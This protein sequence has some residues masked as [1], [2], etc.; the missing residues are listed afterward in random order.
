MTITTT[1]YNVAEAEMNIVTKAKNY[2]D[3]NEIQRQQYI[4]NVNAYIDCLEENSYKKS[5]LTKMRNILKRNV[6][7]YKTD[8]YVHDVPQ[9]ILSFVPKNKNNFAFVWFTRTN[10]THLVDLLQ[11]EKNSDGTKYLFQENVEL[12]VKVADNAHIIYG[13]KNKI[14]VKRVYHKDSDSLEKLNQFVRKYS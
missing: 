8:F 3:M 2:Y 4:E 1:N 11:N 13:S 10:G 9:L 6:K 7:N 14:Q 5:L 12:Y